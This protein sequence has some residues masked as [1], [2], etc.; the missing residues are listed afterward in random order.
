MRQPAAPVAEGVAD[1]GKNSSPHQ[2]QR[3]FQR[4]DEIAHVAIGGN[5]QAAEVADHEAPIE[6]PDHLGKSGRRYLLTG[7]RLRP[8]EVSAH[9]SSVA[10]VRPPGCPAVTA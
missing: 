3:A 8:E 7:D 10:G 1:R 5:E 4:G 2:E 9:F 6:S